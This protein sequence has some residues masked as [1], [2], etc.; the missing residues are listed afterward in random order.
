MNRFSNAFQK[1]SKFVTSEK[2]VF[3]LSTIT[4]NSTMKGE[5]NQYKALQFY[6]QVS[7][8]FP[9]E[10]IDKEKIGQRIKYSM[11]KVSKTIQTFLH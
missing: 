8:V 1:L 4:D 5:L 2:R 9:L 7:H 3:R 11:Q 6:K 10:C